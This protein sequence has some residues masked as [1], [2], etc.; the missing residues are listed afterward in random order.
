MD[1]VTL[2]G[3]AIVLEATEVGN[4]KEIEIGH[5]RMIAGKEAIHVKRGLGIHIHHN[6]IRMLDKEGAGVAMYLMAEDS[7][8]ER[9]DIG[10]IP[11]RNTPLPPQLMVEKLPI[12]PIPA[13]I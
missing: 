7:L 12:L 9:N 6:K 10:V 13:R 8:V 5:N 1:L 4:L 11:A 3:T 2:G